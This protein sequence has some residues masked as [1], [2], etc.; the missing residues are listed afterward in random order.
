MSNWGMYFAV[1]Q[2]NMNMAPGRTVPPQSQIL[3]SPQNI[4]S[5]ATYPASSPYHS[6]Y[7]KYVV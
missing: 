2:G 3:P 6:E 1:I 4:P 7:S 5:P